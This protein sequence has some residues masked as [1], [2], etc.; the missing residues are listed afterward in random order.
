[1]KPWDALLKRML[2]QQLDFVQGCD[3]LD[4]GSGMG[5]TAAHLAACNRVVAV[6]PSAEM[7]SARERK[8][9][10]TQLTGSVEQLAHMPDGS[11]D[12]VICHNVLEY[13]QDRAAVLRELTRV[14]KEGGLFSLCKHNRPGRVMQ[15]AVLLNDFDHAHALLDGSYGVSSQFGPI[16][17]Y[18]DEEPLRACPQLMLEKLYGLRTF[19]DLQ[20]NQQCHGDPAWQE[21]VL[22]LE[23]RVSAMPEYQAIAFF[24]HML[25]RKCQGGSL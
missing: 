14:L 6:E 13:V 19:W 11:F 8:P 1:M 21:A 15:M 3:V 17:Y 5:E 4:F 7:L 25:M 10:Y 18:D 9:V 2:W 23:M 24:H 22:R 16:R 20:Q 12:V